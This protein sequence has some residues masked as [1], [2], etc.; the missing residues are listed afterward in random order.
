MNG[1]A[2]ALGAAPQPAPDGPAD[3]EKPAD[4]EPTA[5]E[6]TE[7]RTDD[8]EV[9]KSVA[10]FEALLPGRVERILVTAGGLLVVVDRMDT[11]A[12]GAAAQVS[13]CVAVAM[14][15]ARSAA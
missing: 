15:D 4:M 3:A 9:G 13:N 7:G 2:S 5:G 14:I 10:R 11:S 6:E 12:E 1:E 8:G